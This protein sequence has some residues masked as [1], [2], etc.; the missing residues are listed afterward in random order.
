[1]PCIIR[2]TRIAPRKLDRE[3]NL[4]TSMKSVRDGIA[5]WLEIDDRSD[6]IQWLYDQRK[7]EPKD[8]RLQIEVFERAKPLGCKLCGAGFGVVPCPHGADTVQGATE[9]PTRSESALAGSAHS[10]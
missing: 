10:E 8:N 5:D 3:D 7:G 4:N 9:A 6:Q 2:L 1:M